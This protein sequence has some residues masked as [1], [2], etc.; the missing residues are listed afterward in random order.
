MCNHV[1][2]SDGG[3]PSFDDPPVQATLLTVYFEPITQFDLT[4]ILPLQQL[5][6]E[7]YPA[8]NQTPPRNRPPSM[9]EVD[10]TSLGTNWPMPGTE[11][12]DIASGR[13]L[14]YQA[15]QISLSWGADSDLPDLKYPGFEAIFSEL[16]SRFDEFVEQVESMAE[17]VV[18][19]GVRC[20]YE[21]YLEDIPGVDYIAQYLSGFAGGVASNRR[22]D[23]S[24][25]VG[26]RFNKD[27]DVSD[28]G[29]EINVAV[30]LDSRRGSVTTLDIEVYATPAHNSPIDGGD[31]REAASQ[32]M[33]DAHV[34]LIDTFL[35]STSHD[36]Q[37]SWGKRS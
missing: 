35:E 5:W 23:Q 15:D 34:A 3:R 32:L 20:A 25:Y 6:A 11:Q 21:N 26:F 33:R 4:F 8:L 36:M 19:H 31:P 7:A 28:D 37:Q 9:P 10:I 13:T 16:T 27:P 1:R 22:M 12:G 2:M 24:R 14:S 30:Q 18:V 17:P 29:S